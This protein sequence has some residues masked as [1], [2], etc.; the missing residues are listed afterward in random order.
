MTIN[1]C[2][3]NRAHLLDIARELY[4]NGHDVKFYTFT[5]KRRLSSYGLDE[6]HIVSVFPFCLLGI[7]LTR[8]F[9]SEFSRKWLRRMLDYSV[10]LRLRKCDVL[11]CQSPHFWATMHYARDKWGAKIILDRGSSHTRVLNQSNILQGSPSM[12]EQ[13]M[14]FDEK[15]YLYA[16]YIAI[17]S[18]FVAKGF[19]EYGIQENKLYINPYGVRD[20][21]FKPTQYDGSYDCIVVGQWS[22]R[23]GSDI[24]IEA[25]KNTDIRILHVGGIRD[26]EFPKKTNFTHIDS[27]PEKDLHLYYA[28]AKILLFPSREDGFGLVLCQ[29]LYCGLDIIASEF[30]GAPT[31]K[32]TLHDNKHITILPQLDAST[33]YQSVS[34]KLL[35]APTKNTTRDVLGNMRNELS[36]AAFGKRYCVF[37]DSICKK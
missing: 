37:L 14:Q 19:V 2:S 6:Q 24:I 12:P 36:W 5:P 15:Q 16:D 35:E 31:L 11:I 33:L 13:F 10:R 29:A 27:V 32:G 1:V 22:K 21:A 23:K 18:S 4:T 34:Q 7:I 9:P 8:F 28:K 25:F 30:T 17:A 20:E 3:S 26:V